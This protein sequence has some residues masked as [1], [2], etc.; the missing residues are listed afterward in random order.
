MT[1]PCK[2]EFITLEKFNNKQIK[3]YHD[4]CDIG[5]HINDKNLPELRNALKELV[6]FY[7]KPE[8][9]YKA[10]K[11][12][13]PII[14]NTGGKSIEFFIPLY[15]D[16]GWT[17]E[18]QECVMEYGYWVKVF[19]QYDKKLPYKGFVAIEIANRSRLPKV[20]R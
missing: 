3:I 1:F 7:G 15:L 8:F 11:W 2:E 17:P 13:T 12:G 10:G 14:G 20:L 16:E 18:T 19:S 4:A 5:I 6:S 9:D